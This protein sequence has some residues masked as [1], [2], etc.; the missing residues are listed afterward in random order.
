VKIAHITSPDF[1]LTREYG[2]TEALVCN[3][4]EKQISEG[5]DVTVIAS[6]QPSDLSVTPISLVKPA[7][8]FPHWVLNW[9]SQRFNGAVHV[10]KSFTYLN[11]NFDIIHN[12]LSEEGI[13]FSLF[14]EGPCLNTLHG[15]AHERLPQYCVS[16]LCS[17]TR[18]TKLVALSRSAYIQHKKFYGNDLIG[19]VHSGVDTE[20]FKFVGAVE[21]NSE[22]ELCYSGRISPDKS[23]KEIISIADILHK[24]GVD[25]HLKV[26]GKFDPRN[27]SYFREVLQMMKERPYV[28]KFINVRRT[29][30]KFLVANSDIFV[31][32]I[33]KTEPFALAP[34]ESMACGT[35][36][37]SLKR[38]AAIDY[39]KNGINGFLCEDIYEMAEATLRYS[40]INR[41][42]CRQI[43]EEKF[44]LDSMYK[45]YMETYKKVVEDS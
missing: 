27:F 43:V 33:S 40:E 44:S 10:C 36:V 19:Y 12:H 23:V 35:P 3:L 42:I 16:R 28:S 15:T 38:A 1:P 39:I 11:S 26:I 13:A 32:P 14:K 24:K 9:M 21:K 29:E 45:Q 7:R 30:L 31:F 20:A 5:H 17:I 6:R 2:G 41:R 25:V 37:V 22:V 18:K 34:L 4:A 8:K